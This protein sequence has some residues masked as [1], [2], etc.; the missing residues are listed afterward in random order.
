MGHPNAKDPIPVRFEGDIGRLQTGIEQL[1]P[2]L[3]C[4]LNPD[5]L[6]IR[7][8]RHEENRLIVSRDGDRAE[9]AYAAP[10]HFFRGL[11]LLIEHIEDA[12]YRTEE[13]VWFTMNGVMFDVTQANTMMTVEHAKMLLRRMALMGLNTV[14]F[15]SEDGYEVKGWPYFGHLRARY[16][17]DEIRDIDDYADAMGIEQIPCIQTL[18]H[19]TEPLKWPCFDGMRESNS[20]LLP[21][22]ERVYEFIEDMI[23]AATAPVRSKRIHIGMDEAEHLGMGNYFQEH[24]KVE[25]GE[26]MI[27]HLNRVREIL[28]RHDLRPMLWCDMFFDAAFG[29]TDGEFGTRFLSDGRPLTVNEEFI[30]DYPR[31]VQMIAYGYDPAPEAHWDELLQKGRLFDRTPVFAGGIWGWTSFCP[32]WPYTFDSTIPALTSCKKNGVKEVFATTWGDEQ[33]ECPVDS[34]LLG[35]QLYAELQYSDTLDREKLAARY[36]FI[37]GADYEDTLLLSALDAIPGTPPGNPDNFNASKCLL[38]QDIL[39]GMF[40]KDLEGLEDEIERHYADLERRFAR[41][42]ARPSDLQKVFGLAQRLA[43]VL[44]RKATMGLRLKVAYDAG[45]RDQLA[46]YANK[47]LPELVRLERELHEYHRALFFSENKALGWETFDFR[48]AALITR[49]KTANWRLN[50]YLAGRV[51]RLEEL[52]EE[53]LYMHGSHQL[54]IHLCYPTMISGSRFASVSGYPIAP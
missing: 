31:D 10:V 32:Q 6:L 7:A 8:R 42:A 9:I 29:K 34:L 26:I 28:K 50:E 51:S 22:N 23:V 3:H 43:S 48:Y 39:C 2:D 13:P 44:S 27:R 1:L 11:G 54:K 4:T 52:E 36:R 24:G 14:M 46:R 41:A 18:A 40:D 15:Y 35:M 30:R 37:T 45:A 25:A 21:E 49:T 19:L 12:A 33:T 47:L 20:C 16:S 5:G 38:W 53:R 17:F